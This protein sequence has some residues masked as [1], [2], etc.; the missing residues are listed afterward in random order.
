MSQSPVVAKLLSYSDWSES[1]KRVLE[2]SIL[3]RLAK[4][5][6]HINQLAKQPPRILESEKRNWQILNNKTRER[7]VNEPNKINESS[8][9]LKRKSI[10]RLDIIGDKDGFVLNLHTREGE[11]IYNIHHHS[12]MLN[13]LGWVLENQL[14]KRQTATLSLN[15]KLSVFESGEIPVGLD[16]LYLKFAPLKPLSDEVFENP[17]AWSKFVVLLV[18][19]KKKMIR[20][21]LLISNTWGELYFDEIQF[22]GAEKDNDKCLRIGQRMY[23]YHHPALRLFV[24]QY[25]TA[26]DPGI[27][28]QVKKAYNTLTTEQDRSKSQKKK[29]YLDRL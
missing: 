7:L 26:Y 12:N 23:H 5:V 11:D 24:C 20:A 27:V 29:P 4:M 1:E 17:A 3:N 22:K 18:Y 28:Y 21:E 6:E 2:K 19:K 10:I 16:Q 25:S 14:Y 8:T 9:Y 15:S 13:V